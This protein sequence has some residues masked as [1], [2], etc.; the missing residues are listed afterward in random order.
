M[1]EVNKKGSGFWALL[2]KLGAKLG[3]VLVK[4][5]K[6]VK[7]G[8]AAASF[9][10]YALLFS[11]KFAILIMVAIGFHEASHVRAAKWLGLKTR[12]WAYLPFLGGVS[13]IEDGYTTYL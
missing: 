6:L 5:L 1:S 9:A 4:T 3:S 8:L 10:G 11:W 2:L 7:V 13:V 12:G